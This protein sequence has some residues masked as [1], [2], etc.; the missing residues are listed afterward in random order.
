[1]TA[2]RLPAVVRDLL[3][4]ASTADADLL[5]RF[6][7]VR[8]EAAFAEL[9]RRHGGPVWDVCRSVLR[10][11]ADA[12]DAFQATFLTLAR[13]AA[14]LRK[15]ASVGAWL[16]GVAVRVAR[17]A[18]AAASRRQAREA[19]YEPVPAADPGECD[20]RAVVHE[21]LAALPARYREPLVAC[22][23]RGLT[24]DD[25][26][27]ELGLSKAAVKK[28]LERGRDRLRAV[29]LS[30]GL[31][32]AVI[33]VAAGP[34]PAHLLDAVTRLAAGA[35]PVPPAILQ[36]V[37]GAVPMTFAKFTAALVL[38]AGV[39][40]A[41]AAQERTPRTP[42][43]PPPPVAESSVKRPQSSAKADV[44]AAKNELDGTWTVK[45]IETNG[46]PI[47]DAKNHD[48]T[49]PAPTFVFDREMCEVTGVRVLYLSRFRFK[50]DPT[51]TPKEIDATMFEG[52]KKGVTVAGIYQVR[53]NELRMCLRLQGAEFGRPK[54]Y[55]TNSGTT[56]Y[57]FV[58]TR[59]GNAVAAPSSEPKF[60]EVLRSGSKLYLV[61]NGLSGKNFPESLAPF[62]ERLD[63]AVKSADRVKDKDLTVVLFRRSNLNTGDGLMTGFTREQL[64][65]YAA[66]DQLRRLGKLAEHA[67]T[68][69][70]VP[71]D[72]V[73]LPPEP[74]Q[75]KAVGGAADV[76][77]RVVVRS[78]WVPPEPPGDFANARVG[79]HG[80]LELLGRTGV[81]RV[82]VAPSTVKVT[83]RNSSGSTHPPVKLPDLKREPGPS[84]TVDVVGGSYV[85]LSTQ[86]GP[87][88]FL[89]GR[90]SGA[91]V[92]IGHDV[93][94]LPQERYRV[95][96]TIDVTV[97]SRVTTLKLDT[98]AFTIP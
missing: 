52:P 29:L 48:E 60:D 9:V 26:A 14:Y 85:G 98:T 77:A 28:R 54:G 31:A 67:W 37:E 45:W 62:A 21:A 39:G 27:T 49:L 57:T 41:V 56:L 59:G 87:G 3:R 32:P 44:P 19:E 88:V 22:Y 23:L 70:R 47:Y 16:H 74:P 7:A 6:V 65:R 36:L 80:Y 95:D 64:G 43:E 40:L 8:D 72:A 42:N 96:G 30:R 55:V 68:I 34:V 12:D 69:G 5:A 1:M 94:R 93:Y 61:L 66:E 63:V 92:H 71:K 89:G 84:M 35:A 76:S 20:V 33:L 79:R 15:P 13:R 82:S 86:A 24:H 46:A 73:P 2:A 97:G 4:G 18:R 81:V 38:A 58:L 90:P 10:N 25:T 51:T 75:P 78:D 91:D 83:I 50:T 53:D 17:K 11:A